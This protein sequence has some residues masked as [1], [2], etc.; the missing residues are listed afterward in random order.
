M[1]F[2]I[3]L[4]DKT[5]FKMFILKHCLCWL[6][7]CSCSKY[8]I[9]KVLCEIF[10]AAILNLWRHKMESNFTSQSF[11]NMA[12]MRKGVTAKSGG[13]YCVAG[14]PNLQSCKNSWSSEGISMHLF[15]KDPEIRKK[16]V[17]F[18]RR[19]R[20]DF[21]PTRT[22]ALCSIHFEASCFQQRFTLAKL[23]GESS[24]PTKRRLE[25]DAIPT[26]Y[27]CRERVPSRIP[28]GNAVW[29]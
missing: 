13:L 25:R 3:S 5:G 8:E 12:A 4:I 9:N 17:A 28:E 14:G 22:S 1:K 27:S 16:W 10:R 6:Y 15:P 29:S 21:E 7:L 19:H 26:I 18:V 20:A 24:L 11:R 23:G 2:F